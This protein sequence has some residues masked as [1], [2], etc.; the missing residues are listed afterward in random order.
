MNYKKID[1]LDIPI[2]VLTTEQ[3]LRKIEDFVASKKPRQICTVNPEIIIETQKNER[4]KKILQESALNTADGV[5]IAWA[6]KYLSRKIKSEK[7]SGASR[8]LSNVFWLK[9]TL[10][11]I[12]FAKKWLLS[13]IPERV[14]GV[15]LVWK[16]AELAEKKSW[17]I[18]LLGAGEGIAKKTA[19]KMISAYP[20]L[21]IVG[22][23]AGFP[24]EKGLVKK[25]AET[26]PDILFVAFGSP[27]QEIFISQNLRNLKVSVAIGVGGSFDFIAG[28]A[29]RA[30]KFFQKLGLEWLWRLILEPKRALRI[31]NATVKFVCLVFRQG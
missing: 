10:L 4:F 3:T 25:I 22:A 18:Y 5:G 15:D 6:A 17:G 13:E 16:I 24:Q 2:D 19:Q 30:P 8:F 23:Y 29:K 9:I 1:I 26:K 12:I 28:R 20:N 21:K 7:Y 11:S 31:Y 27:R 14:T